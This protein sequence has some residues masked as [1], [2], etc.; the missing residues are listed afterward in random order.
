MR[1]VAALN[2]LGGRQL[3]AKPE[4]WLLTAVAPLRI[5]LLLINKWPWQVEP[6]LRLPKGEREVTCRV[7]ADDRLKLPV[8]MRSSR[9]RLLLHA[10][11]AH[12]PEP[13]GTGSAR[14]RCTSFLV[15]HRLRWVSAWWRARR[16]PRWWIQFARFRKSARNAAAA[17][18]SSSKLFN[19][20][21]AVVIGWERYG[22][23]DQSARELA[24]EAIGSDAFF[25]SYNAREGRGL[26]ACGLSCSTV[27]RGGR[28]SWTGRSLYI[29]LRSR[30]HISGSLSINRKANGHSP[31]RRVA[32]AT[33]RFHSGR[34][35][36][37]HAERARSV[38]RTAVGWRS[39]SST[40]S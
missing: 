5:D 1:W 13:S 25:F 29:P 40:N 14:N 11:A 35:S 20:Y 9:D 19:T 39:C 27:K 36:V 17:R 38:S 7:V 2:A 32:S 15:S 3:A 26:R 31:K 4:A 18:C 34:D 37:V 24:G 21:A 6:T 23:F 33:G 12:A 22:G 16:R 10:H 28:T 30:I 8:R